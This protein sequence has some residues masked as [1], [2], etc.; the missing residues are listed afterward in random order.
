MFQIPEV[1]RNKHAIQYF[2][3]QV[4]PSNMKQAKELEEYIDSKKTGNKTADPLP[5]VSGQ[6]KQGGIIGGGGGG[7]PS[8]EP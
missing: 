5:D 7:D 1:R 4:E 6:G 8:L 3:K 2:L